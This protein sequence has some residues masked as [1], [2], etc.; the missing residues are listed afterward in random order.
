[1][2]HFIRNLLGST[3]LLQSEH[4]TGLSCLQPVDA[5]QFY[6]FIATDRNRSG[7]KNNLAKSLNDP[8]SLNFYRIIYLKFNWALSDNDTIMKLRY[9]TLSDL[10]IVLQKIMW[11]L[12]RKTF[13]F[14][15]RFRR[16]RLS[17]SFLTNHGRNRHFGNFTILCWKKYFHNRSHRYAH[18]L[19]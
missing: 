18:A 10:I 15:S 2:F 14:I 16:F 17:W 11:W 19:G 5:S 8:G 13:L 7:L 3:G 4:S 12:T 1:M 9:L 6:E